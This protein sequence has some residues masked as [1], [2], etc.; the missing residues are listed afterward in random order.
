MTGVCYFQPHAGKQPPAPFICI[1]KLSS[2]KL[3][4]P[5]YSSLE[6]AFVMA[7]KRSLYL[8]AIHGIIK[9][10][11][12]QIKAENRRYYHSRLN[13]SHVQYDN[14]TFCTYIFLVFSL[15]S[16]IIRKGN[17]TNFWSNCFYQPRG[18]CWMKKKICAVFQPRGGLSSLGTKKLRRTCEN[19]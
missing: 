12:F 19:T 2:R 18:E 9:R 13:C 17:V 7:G 16:C 15:F 10:P 4:Q 8:Y 14:E 5:N 1:W 11:H 3:S 6:K